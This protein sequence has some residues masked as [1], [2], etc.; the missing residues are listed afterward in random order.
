M[1]FE[2]VYGPYMPLSYVTNGTKRAKIIFLN[3][4]RGCSQTSLQSSRFYGGSLQDEHIHYV[5]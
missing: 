1:F 5:Y 3:H 4:F 2:P